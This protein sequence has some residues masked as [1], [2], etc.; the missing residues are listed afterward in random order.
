MPDAPPDPDVRASLRA[1]LEA[2]GCVRKAFLE[3]DPLELYVI[4]DR[5]ESE[6][7]EPLARALLAQHGFPQSTPVHVAYVPMPEPRR[8]VRFVSARLT[9]PRPGRAVAAVEL[10]WAGQT[11]VHESE[12][13]SGSA[14]ELRLAAMATVRTL[15]A[16]LGGRMQFE[17][18]GIKGLKAFDTDVVVAL[19]S[20]EQS[21]GHALV[22]AALATDNLY[23]SAALAVLN[24]TNRMLGNYLSQG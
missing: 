24:A 23:R 22:G 10:E 15:E 11:F 14:L 18:V 16:I 6:P 1:D 7:A 4:C 12:G 19:L 2:I 17:L 13:E 21:A 20:S 3:E 9:S 8:R 5:E